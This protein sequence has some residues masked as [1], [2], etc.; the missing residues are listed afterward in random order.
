MSTSLA[1]GMGLDV[2]RAAGTPAASD[3][4][5]QAAL[6]RST[7]TGEWFG[8]DLSEVFSS[9]RPLAFA[10]TRGVLP[11]GLAI[12][13]DVGLIHG[14]PRAPGRHAL[15]ISAL[16]G[17]DTVDIPVS[18]DVARGFDG[19]QGGAIRRLERLGI[20]GPVT[21][22]TLACRF[23][24]PVGHGSDVTLMHANAPNTYQLRVLANGR[25][26]LEVWSAAGVQTTATSIPAGLG[27]NDG[28]D[29]TLIVA[30]DAGAGTLVG[31]ID[32]EPLTFN[33]AP[34]AE[35]DLQFAATFWSIAANASGTGNP[36][37]P[38]GAIWWA[39]VEFGAA[40]EPADFALDPRIPNGP[41]LFFGGVLADW[42]GGVNHGTGANW[43][44]QHGTWEAVAVRDPTPLAFPGARGFG[45]FATGGRGQTVYRVTNTDAAGTGSLPWA[46]EQAEGNGGGYIII[47]PEAEGPLE[48]TSILRVLGDNITIDAR[49]QQGLG[50]WL[51][52][53]PIWIESSNVVV[54][55]LRSYPGSNFL[56]S[57]TS[58]RDAFIVASRLDNSTQ[59]NLYFDRCDAMFSIDE[60]FS[61]FPYR[62]GSTAANVTIDGTIIAE[63]CH[64]N[65]HIDEGRPN[66][67]PPLPQRFT[68][69]GKAFITST[70][71]T[72]LTIHG[73]LLAS[74]DDRMPRLTG[75]SQEVIS[76]IIANFG[77]NSIQVSS[78][79][80]ADFINVAF[81]LGD[82]PGQPTTHS[83]KWVQGTTSTTLE[84]V[85]EAGSFNGA[86][87]EAGGF[88]DA[89]MVNGWRNQTAGNVFMDPAATQNDALFVKSGAATG[90]LSYDAAFFSLGARV[91]SLTADGERHPFAERVVRYVTEPVPF[92]TGWHGTPHARNMP[93]D[94]LRA[95]GA[96]VASPGDGQL[97]VTLPAANTAL[98]PVASRPW[99]SVE[100]TVVNAYTRAITNQMAATELP[101]TGETWDADGITLPG[102]LAGGAVTFSGLPAGFYVARVTWRSNGVAVPVYQG[103]PVAVAA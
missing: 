3:P 53:A 8:L 92:S 19:V 29:H 61:V 102:S 64:E 34:A 88:N 93:P 36:I 7:R 101:L 83:A 59:E 43:T 76:T 73:S 68:D 100:V 20:T 18:L 42:E 58:G 95:V 24:I 70:E 38:G 99:T 28:R 66:D 25:I 30:I 55:H 91:G 47:E 62:S 69:H 23:R 9:S 103:R 85:Y 82:R 51:S 48:L 11:D 67:N 12:M 56:G 80:T 40:R 89:A 97:T 86:W 77:S 35:S 60:A 87:T 74:G 10:L 15:T 17:G 98:P 71:L 44:V 72:G 52:G 14:A 5:A 79:A 65:L 45:R 41:Q 32:G 16:S 96:T 2:L 31:W 37:P 49:R 81:L 78:G 6:W 84:V 13:P 39:S 94:E 22:L 46:I 21:Q 4:P 63:P 50:L 57:S 1:I 27:F 75:Q 33:A 26:R 54:R 90:A